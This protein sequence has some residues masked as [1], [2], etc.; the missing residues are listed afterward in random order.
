MPVYS[1]VALGYWF[2]VSLARLLEG[3]AWVDQVVH[4]HH[5]RACKGKGAW[6]GKGIWEGKQSAAAPRASA[7]FR[8][9]AWGCGSR[10]AHAGSGREG[11]GATNAAYTP[12]NE[13]ERE[14]FDLPE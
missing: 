6:A 2:A 11:P 5:Q 1:L 14:L 3:D 9:F 7:R 10:R 4:L 8:R 12:F 13:T